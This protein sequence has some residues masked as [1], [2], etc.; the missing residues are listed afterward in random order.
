MKKKNKTYFIV[1]SPKL[2]WGEDIE[3]DIFLKFNISP[4]SVE[5]HFLE[6][7]VIDDSKIDKI[8]KHI[9]K[10]RKDIKVMRYS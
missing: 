9:R 4:I 7:C 1:Y 8:R 10:Q 3:Y 6:Y 2:Y 5:K